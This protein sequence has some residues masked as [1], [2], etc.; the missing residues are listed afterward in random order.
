LPQG[1]ALAIVKQERTRTSEID[2]DRRDAER[3]REQKAEAVERYMNSEAYVRAGTRFNAELARERE[4]DW[5]DPRYPGGF[6]Q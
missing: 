5:F 3:Y 1:P 4:A 2:R 6:R